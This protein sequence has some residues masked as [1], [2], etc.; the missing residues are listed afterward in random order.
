MSEKPPLRRKKTCFLG[1]SIVSLTFLVMLIG[2]VG[3]Y[4]AHA[5]PEDFSHYHELMAEANPTHGHQK[6]M[7]SYT[8]TQQQQCVRKDIHFS[9][10]LNRLHFLLACQEAHVIFDHQS[11]KTELME[12]LTDVNCLAQQE[13]FYA[14][15]ATG[16]YLAKDDPL[17]TPW[18]K[19]YRGTADK[20]FFSYKNWTFKAHNMRL[21]EYTTP[22]HALLIDAEEVPFSQLSLSLEALQAHYDGKKLFLDEEVRFEHPIGSLFAGRAVMSPAVQSKELLES[23]KLKNDVILDL[24]EQGTLTSQKALFHFNTLQARF[25]GSSEK[26]PAVLYTSQGVGRQFPISFKSHTIDLTL[27]KDLA[28]APKTRLETLTAEGDV[29]IDYGGDLYLSADKAHYTYATEGQNALSFRR[30]P[31]KIALNSTGKDK[32]C[33]V[34]N[35]QGDHLTGTAIEID[36]NQRKVDVSDARGIFTHTHIS[37]SKLLVPAQPLATLEVEARQL[38][39]DLSRDLLLLKGD[40]VLNHSVIGTFQSDRELRIYYA[41]IKGQRQLRAIESEGHL[42]LRSD[43]EGKKQAHWLVCDGK[44]RVDHEAMT[45]TFQS[46]SDAHG[47]VSQNKQVLFYDHLGEIQ[48]D[49]ITITYLQ[50][51]GKYLASKVRLEG[52][53]FMVDHKAGQDSSAS[54]RPFVHYAIADFIDY[55]P[56]D[57]QMH[58]YSEKGRRVLFYDKINHLQVSAPALKVSRDLQTKK[59]SV[60]GIGDVRFNFLDSELEQLRKYSVFDF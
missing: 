32:L 20:A 9:K 33:H 40:I 57:K 14:D 53:V 55:T 4:I 45:L 10:G 21:V 5:T 7:I 15:A 2:G 19:I 50:V 49:K 29:A 36:T 58:L 17:A 54:A 16:N 26:N 51:E 6:Q 41:G 22:G 28:A 44:M 13:L 42:V 31:G 3:Y 59:E 46:Y 8:A 34:V 11:G 37:A 48:A 35:P 23:I 25:Y 24:K 27:A 18:Q 30:L 56:A 47:K 38:T 12:E 52:N 43:D 39:W 1:M 60:K